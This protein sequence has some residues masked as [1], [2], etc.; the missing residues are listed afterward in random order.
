[1]K[2]LTEGIAG[3]LLAGLILLCYPL[4][5]VVAGAFSGWV[6]GSVFPN[7]I[8]ILSTTLFG[9]ALAGWQLGACLGFVGAFLKTKVYSKD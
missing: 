1:M 3:L 2:D 8:L 4:I 5:G 9:K 7:T 6:V